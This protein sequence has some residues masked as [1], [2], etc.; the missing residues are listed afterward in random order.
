[1]EKIA[2]NRGR[3][4]GTTKAAKGL[5]DSIQITMRIGKNDLEEVDKAARSMRISRSGLMRLAVFKLI[6]EEKLS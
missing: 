5:D 3:P 2:Q 1:M 6:N 4:K